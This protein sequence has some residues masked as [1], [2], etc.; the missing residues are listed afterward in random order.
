[1]NDSHFSFPVL[2]ALFALFAGT[3]LAQDVP[4]KQYVMI[5]RQPQP[6]TEAVRQRVTEETR[7][8]AKQQNDKG[9]K[10]DPHILA[11]EGRWIGPDGV[12][13]TVPATD[14]GPVTALLFFEAR[15]L[16]QA[17]DVA[18]T[19]PAVRYGVSVE[20]RPWAPPAAV[21]PPPRPDV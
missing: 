11:P 7:A 12:S 19:H 1:M 5:F 4:R 2:L 9:H 10:L 15:D 6:L 3:A 17:V 20:V 8:W 14:L 18:R 16:A 13:G 21:Q